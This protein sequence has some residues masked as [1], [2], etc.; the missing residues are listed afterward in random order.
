LNYAPGDAINRDGLSKQLQ[1]PDFIFAFGS[2]ADMARSAAGLVALENDPIL[3]VECA[4]QQLRILILCAGEEA[5]MFTSLP[6][7]LSYMLT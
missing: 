3:E 4:L 2:T 1:C 6:Q 5:I 7:I